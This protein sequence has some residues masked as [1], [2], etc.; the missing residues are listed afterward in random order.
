M[1]AL[2]EQMIRGKTRVDRLDEVRNL[3]LWG[4]DLDDVSLL[5]KLATVEILSLSVNKIASLRDFRH[6]TRLQELYLRKNEVSDVSELTYLTSLRD[7]KVLW[8]SDN[9]C[10]DHPFYRQLTVSDHDATS[11]IMKKVACKI[12]CLMRQDL[13]NNLS[14]PPSDTYA[15]CPG[16]A[17]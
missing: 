13:T 14:H 10:A 6:C 3:N 9:P 8:L 12:L 1:V 11:S 4:Q 5:A 15:A 16:K 2:T 7:L 17:R